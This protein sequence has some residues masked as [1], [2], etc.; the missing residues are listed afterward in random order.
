MMCRSIAVTG[1]AIC[2]GVRSA[3]DVS[4]PGSR[5]ARAVCPSRTAARS[6]SWAD[7]CEHG[8]QVLLAFPQLGLA[9]FRGMQKSSC[10]GHPVAGMARRRCRA[11]AAAK[12][13]VLPGLP[14]PG[15]D[16]DAVEQDLD[17]TDVAGEVADLGG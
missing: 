9:G 1:S 5:E 3:R 13:V 8:L 2:R 4:E 14:V 12:V 15:G 6:S 11:V 16:G 17:G 10:A 7:G